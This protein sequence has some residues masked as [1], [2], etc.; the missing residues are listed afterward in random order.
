MSLS[1]Q[2]IEIYEE[3][4]GDELND[5]THDNIDGEVPDALPRMKKRMETYVTN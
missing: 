1:S 4:I 2:H 3:Y 5:M